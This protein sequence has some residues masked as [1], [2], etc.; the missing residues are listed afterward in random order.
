VANRV[1]RSAD[2]TRLGMNA[3]ATKQRRVNPA[4]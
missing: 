1:S 2:Q 3:Q 4:G